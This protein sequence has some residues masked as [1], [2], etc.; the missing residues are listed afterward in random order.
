[1]RQGCDEKGD[2]ILE[3]SKNGL[4]KTG[5]KKG[6]ATLIIEE[7]DYHSW[8]GETVYINILVTNIYSLFV[9]N[10]YKVLFLYF[11]F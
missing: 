4:I 7:D 11:N 5:E 9:E 2:N 10:S 3:V 6:K 1:M 8:D